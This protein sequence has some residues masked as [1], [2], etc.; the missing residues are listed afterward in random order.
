[1]QE[2][3][4]KALSAPRTFAAVDNPEAWL[5]TVALNLIRNRWRRRHRLRR[6]LRRPEARP[7]Q[8][9][10]TGPDHVAPVDAL[11][12]LPEPQRVTIALHYIADLP[13]AEIAASLRVSEGTVKSRLARGRKALATALDEHIDEVP[14]SLPAQIRQEL[15]H[16]RPA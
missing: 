16:V 7:A 8:V 12:T 4:V 6:I 5:R 10:G 3:F 14:A 1:M 11:R 9:P 13:I 15:S 2:A